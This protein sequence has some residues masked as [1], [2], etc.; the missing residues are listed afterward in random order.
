M[1]MAVDIRHL[2]LELGG[3]PILRDVS[4]AVEKGSYLAMVGPNG[5]GKTSLLRCV[6]RLLDCWRG[7]IKVGGQDV[8]T[9]G[10]RELARRVAYV[11]QA[12]GRISP[13]TVRELVMMSR[14]PHLSPFSPVGGEDRDQ[15]AAALERTGMAV[16]AERPL[17]TLSGGERQK[18]FIAAA[19]AQ[20]AAILLLDEP[21]TFLDPGHERDIRSI[22]RRA[23]DED[24]ATIILVTH[25][26]NA[27][28]L[29]CDKVLAL[30][31]GTVAFYG[32]PES[33]M[34]GAVL[35]R[36]YG[37]DFLLGDHPR[38]GQSVILPE[39]ASR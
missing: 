39:R 31:E 9:V 7:S 33:F 20:D 15:V 28:A 18:V 35:E 27:A 11:P 3:N 36:I 13:F 22:L 23:N 16:F 10:R 25:D 32:P 21:T 8:E 34:D 38:T 5:A 2:R 12:G 14:Y 6:G 4:V 37:R 17:D 1:D 19:L 29:E 26:L 30:Q 24:G